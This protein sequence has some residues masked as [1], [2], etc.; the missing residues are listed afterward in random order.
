MSH[1]IEWRI[2]HASINVQKNINSSKYSYISIQHDH[3]LMMMYD[4]HMCHMDSFNITTSDVLKYIA[5]LID[6]TNKNCM[7]L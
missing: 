4:V 7:C 6:Q 5:M 3:G 2:H 1:L